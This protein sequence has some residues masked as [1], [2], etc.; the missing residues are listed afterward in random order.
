[1]WDSHFGEAPGE[2]RRGDEFELHVGK[3]CMAVLI[4]SCL[5]AASSLTS[6]STVIPETERSWLLNISYQAIIMRTSTI[7]S[8]KERLKFIIIQ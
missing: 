4:F 2:A 7:L 6:R 8:T 3:N 5:A 1:M